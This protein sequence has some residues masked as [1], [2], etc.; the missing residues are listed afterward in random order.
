MELGKRGTRLEKDRVN[1]VLD[2]KYCDREGASSI[3][4]TGKLLDQA[5]SGAGSSGIGINVGERELFD[6]TWTKLTL[7]PV[8]NAYIPNQCLM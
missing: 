3:T 2:S 6:L 8:N 5:N 1:S 4:V 7:I